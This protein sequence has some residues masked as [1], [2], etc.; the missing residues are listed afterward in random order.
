M[1]RKKLMFLAIGLAILVASSGLAAFYIYTQNNP[2]DGKIRVACVGDSITEGTYYP[3]DLEILLGTNYSVGNFGVGGSAVSLESGK[4]YM[5]EDAFQEAKAFH[6]NIV[7]IMM[8]ANDASPLNSPSNDSFVGDYVQLIGAFQLLSSNPKMYIV[9]PPP[10]FSDET[11]LNP[12]FFLKNIIPNIEKVAEQTNL[13]IIDVH[14][15]L[16]N[17][18]NLFPDGVHPNADGAQLIANTI[19]KAITQHPS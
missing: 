12:V 18:S 2:K 7:I 4:P 5:N 9:K 13:P 17:S 11:G 6:P 15:A 14:S 3:M 8:G 10:V 16:V 19:Y 1:H